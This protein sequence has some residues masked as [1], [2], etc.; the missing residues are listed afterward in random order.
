MAS[1]WPVEILPAPEGETLGSL[2]VKYQC[3][4]AF[5]RREAA[6]TCAKHVRAPQIFI[7]ESPATGLHTAFEP[8]KR[9]PAQ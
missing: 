8:I 3:L 9:L 1:D 6:I 4:G 2:V 7:Y 5:Q